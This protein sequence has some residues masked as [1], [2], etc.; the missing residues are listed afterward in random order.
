MFILS[1]VPKKIVSALTLIVTLLL[2][3]QTTH[4]Q[5]KE[6]GVS[7]FEKVIINPHIQVEFVEGGDS[8]VI[9]NS[10]EVD[11]EK[12]VV[13]TI[14]E[15]LHVYLKDA[16]VYTK[17]E[18]VDNQHHR[19]SIYKGT[20]AK[21]TINYKG[22]KKISLRGEEEIVFKSPIE[23]GT[24]RASIYGEPKITFNEITVEN[25][26]ATV[27]G[28]AQIQILSGD[29]SNQKYVCYGS[30]NIDVLGVENRNAKVVN[31][32]DGKFHLNVSESLKVTSFGTSSVYYQGNPKIHRGINIGESIIATI[33]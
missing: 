9:I 15:V 30:G 3:I 29:I 6:Y 13:E 26:K 25:F 32:G 20:I 17:T 2:G 16:R 12:L 23:L 1:V 7:S 27:Y 10:C 22:L 5:I 33:E 24:F 8:K 4:S 11:P 18:K 19:K 31:Y 21:I 28:D 14:N